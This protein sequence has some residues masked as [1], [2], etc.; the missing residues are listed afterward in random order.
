MKKIITSLFRFAFTLVKTPVVAAYKAAKA[1][2]VF[3][4]KAVVATAKAICDGVI[5]TAKTL[6]YAAVFT[7]ENPEQAAK[8][9]CSFIW[10]CLCTMGRVLLESLVWTV[11]HTE[12]EYVYSSK[13]R[14]WDREVR[15]GP[16]R[17]IGRRRCA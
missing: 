7:V 6:Y 5:F 17:G 16:S 14:R 3:A 8:N 4:A 15:V 10:T 1:V 2:V 12:V 11:E 13:D 9:V